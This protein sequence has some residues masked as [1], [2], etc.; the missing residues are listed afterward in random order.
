[1]FADMQ[2]IFNKDKILLS[3]PKQFQFPGARVPQIFT[4]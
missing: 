3:S 4:C 1:M 2:T